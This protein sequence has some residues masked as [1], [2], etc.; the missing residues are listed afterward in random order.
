MISPNFQSTPYQYTL[1]RPV[2]RTI[3]RKFLAIR[4]TTFS[5][6]QGST[7]TSYGRSFLAVPMNSS[8]PKTSLFAS[9]VRIICFEISG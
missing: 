6:I 9:V 3:A 5:F 4:I 7:H 2:D 1:N 8:A